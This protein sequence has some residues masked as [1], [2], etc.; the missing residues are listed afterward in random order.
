MRVLLAEA[1]KITPI[2]GIGAFGVGGLGGGGIKAGLWEVGGK[3][4]RRERNDFGHSYY[5][6]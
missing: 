5:T 1:G 6:R 3:G 4:R 2:G